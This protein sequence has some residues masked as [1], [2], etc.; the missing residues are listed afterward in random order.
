MTM[1]LDEAIAHAK[2][3]ASEKRALAKTICPWADDGEETLN[4]CIDCA[5]DHEHLADWLEELK[6]RREAESTSDLIS[7]SDIREKVVGMA[8]NK[9]DDLDEIEFEINATLA[10]ICELIDNA[11]AVDLWQMRQEATENALKKAEVLYARPQI[12]WKTTVHGL[13]A[14]KVC[15]GC[16]AEYLFDLTYGWKLCPKCGAEVKGGAE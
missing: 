2:E 3:V 14:Y 16:G 9:A 1:T 10:N 4:E 15:G 6:K 12:E 8:I 11:Q 5:I 7:R 13:L